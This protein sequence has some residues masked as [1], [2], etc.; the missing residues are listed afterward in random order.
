MCATKFAVKF[1]QQSAFWDQ[2]TAD[3]TASEG[4]E[5]FD[6]RLVK[7]ARGQGLRKLRQ[8]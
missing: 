1:L 5:C 6:L 4:G 3:S 8:S 7:G 2:P